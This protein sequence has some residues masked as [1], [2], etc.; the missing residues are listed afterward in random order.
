[1]GK[2]VSKKLSVKYSHKVLD[3]AKQSATD[4]LKPN[5]KRVI[6]KTTEVTGD[7]IGNKTAAK[8]YIGLANF[9]PK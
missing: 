5:S 3:H 6:K 7:L 4:D 2:N 8:N 9:T 1:M